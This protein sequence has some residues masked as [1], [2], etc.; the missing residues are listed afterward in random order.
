M[1]TFAAYVVLG[2]VSDVIITWYYL[3]IASR[4]AF[5]ASILAVVIPLLS[6][7]VIAQAL[8]THDLTCV[9]AFV[10]G[11]GAGTYWAVKKAK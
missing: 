4:R 3:A 11:N 2:I 7:A 1:L 10:L 6:F 5:Q 8:E 9:L